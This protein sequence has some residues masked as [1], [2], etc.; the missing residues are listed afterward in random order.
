MTDAR[1]FRGAFIGFGNVAA[2]GHLPGWLAR[3]DVEIVA[4]S[5][6]TA[7]RREVFLAACPGGRWFDSPDGLLASGGLD[8]V[9]ICT[10]PGSHA[11]LIAKA[12]AA[13]LHVLCEKPL[14]TQAGDAPAL[15]AARRLAAYMREALRDLN[16]QDTA[17]LAGGEMRLPDPA[18]IPAAIC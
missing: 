7:S 9:D 13:G 14:V 1:K 8:F 16:A 12:L 5:D 3:G 2:N 15:A 4:A 17:R 6:A 11:A 10:P 18:T